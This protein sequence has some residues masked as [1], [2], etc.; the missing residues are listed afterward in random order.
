M[1]FINAEVINEIISNIPNIIIYFVPGFLF[2]S[3]NSFIRYTEKSIEKLVPRSIAVSFIFKIVFDCILSLFHIDVQK[4]QFTVPYQVFLI[5]ISIVLPILFA[6]LLNLEK[7]SDLISWLCNGRT[8]N[9]NFWDDVLGYNKDCWLKVYDD[10]EKIYFI[11][12]CEHAEDNQRLPL[13]CLY[14][15]AIRHYPSKE[16]SE[17]ELIAEYDDCIE[18]QPSGS[19]EHRIILDLSKYSRYEVITA[20]G[21]FEAYQKKRDAE[22]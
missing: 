6:K 4:N 13:V 20:V 21:G 7:F 2:I 10:K 22:M 1:S 19:L 9:N 5:A 15:Y 17:G 16:D 8:Q 12:M 14:N 3:L 11:G 18:D